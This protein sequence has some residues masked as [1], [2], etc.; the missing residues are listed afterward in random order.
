MQF[1]NGYKRV[2]IK[3]SWITENG[4]F[5][6][7]PHN[8]LKIIEQKSVFGNVKL[9]TLFIFVLLRVVLNGSCR[10]CKNIPDVMKKGS[11]AWKLSSII[12]N[13]HSC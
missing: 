12:L 1:H 5:E 3:S 4:G 10:S 7:F 6:N 13:L 9:V 8:D 11:F 2:Q